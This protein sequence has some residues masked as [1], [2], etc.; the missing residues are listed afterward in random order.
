MNGLFESSADTQKADSSGADPGVLGRLPKSRPGMRSPRREDAA[1]REARQAKAAASAAQGPA[2]PPGTAA[3]PPPP[4]SDQ[5]R[6]PLEDAA[7]AGVGLA[8]GAV[9]LGFR[10]AGGALGALRNAGR[11]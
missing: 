7:R 9:E 1:A 2:K 3:A 4:G 6:G 11:R 8:V 5:S 10:V